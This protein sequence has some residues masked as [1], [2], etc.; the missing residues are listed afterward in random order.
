[1]KT[2]DITRIAHALGLTLFLPFLAYSLGWQSFSSSSPGMAT[3]SSAI[4]GGALLA[5]VCTSTTVSVPGAAAG[6]TVLAA[7]NTY[8][9]DGTFWYA[10]VSSAGVVT[11]KA[12]AIIALTPASSTYTVRIFH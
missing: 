6:M 1:M 12:C 3:T 8:P 5:G 10:Y 2:R 9:G 11:V 4:G 7:P